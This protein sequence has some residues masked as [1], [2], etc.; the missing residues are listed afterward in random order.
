[1]SFGDKAMDVLKPEDGNWWAWGM[2][3]LGSR[4]EAMNVLGGP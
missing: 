3:A 4:A 2:R 1:M